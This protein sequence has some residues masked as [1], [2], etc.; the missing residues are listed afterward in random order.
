MDIFIPDKENSEKLFEKELLA[1]LSSFRIRM[2]ADVQAH[3]LLPLMI[4]IW[5]LINDPHVVC[6]GGPFRRLQPDRKLI[7]LAA[8]LWSDS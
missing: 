5:S 2:S 4:S 8:K 3:H 7:W 1:H 6:V